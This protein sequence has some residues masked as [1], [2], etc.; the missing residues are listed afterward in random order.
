VPAGSECVKKI[1]DV[2]TSTGLSIKAIRF[3]CDKGLLNPTGRTESKY[4]LFDENS[5]YELKLIRSLRGLDMTVDEVKTFM[6]ARR[7]GECS[8]QRLQARMREKKGEIARKM[9]DLLLLQ[10]A[11]DG[12]LANWKECGGRKS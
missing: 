8:C 1:G 6:D 5:E 4:R 2:A 3:Y 11:I 10:E 7:S 9:Q 12:M